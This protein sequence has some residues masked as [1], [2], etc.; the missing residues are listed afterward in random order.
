M[1]RASKR[2]SSFSSRFFYRHFPPHPRRT[3]IPIPL[4]PDPTPPHYSIRQTSP[5]PSTP[6]GGSGGSVHVPFERRVMEHSCT[7]SSTCFSRTQSAARRKGDTYRSAFPVRL[8]D[9]FPHS[10]GLPAD[11]R[12][13]QNPAQ[14][15]L[16]IDS[17]TMPLRILQTYL[18][19]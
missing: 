16:T 1:R 12:Q 6:T 4:L 10:D 3:S 2:L 7:P 15:L 9:V 13:N 8:F 18:K 5:L 19:N 14:N 17:V 11:R